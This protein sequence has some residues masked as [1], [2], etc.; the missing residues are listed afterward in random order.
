[1]RVIAKGTLKRFWEAGHTDAERPLIEWYA[2]MSKASWLTPQALK[3][4]IR[5][6]SI[7]KARRAVFNI[8]GNKYR[9][10]VDIDYL[11][12]AAWVKF[13]GTHEQY[14]QID[15]ETI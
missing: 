11:R 15:A 12:Q 2:L 4:E 9:I 13:I 7:L 3:A 10:V 14:D 5:T 1:M 6:A 8:G